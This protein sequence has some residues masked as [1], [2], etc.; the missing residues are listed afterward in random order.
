[1][2]SKEKSSE[3][4]KSHRK[5]YSNSKSSKINKFDLTQSV[6]ANRPGRKEQ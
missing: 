2:F 1:M 3:R 5:Q 4:T 6:L